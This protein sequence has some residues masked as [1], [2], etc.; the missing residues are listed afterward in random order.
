MNDRPKQHGD[1]GI[2]QLKRNLCSGISDFHYKLQ[3]GFGQYP[4]LVTCDILRFFFVFGQDN[5]DNRE[6]TVFEKPSIQ[7]CLA[8]SKVVFAIKMM[9]GNR[10]VG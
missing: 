9:I 4:I 6:H 10:I 1:Q 3:I 2:D 5:N 7:N 8:V